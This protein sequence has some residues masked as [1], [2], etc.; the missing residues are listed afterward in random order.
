MKVFFS[1]DAE[2]RVLG[3]G[4]SPSTDNHIEVELD[5]EAD[6]LKSPLSYVIHEGELMHDDEYHALILEEER[7]LA[8]KPSITE[9][10]DALKSVS[11]ALLG[12]EQ[13]E[14]EQ[15]VAMTLNKALQKFASSLPEEEALELAAMYPA[16]EESR[17]YEVGDY[18]RHGLNQDGEPQV[19]VVLQKHDSQSDWSPPATASLFKALGFTEDG[20]PTWVQPLGATD[21]YQKDDVVSFEGVL[22]RS[23][24]DNN[25]WAPNVYGWVLETASA[26]SSA[27]KKK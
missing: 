18:V 21:A 12:G 26:P 1:A 24:M 5:T 15:L 14:N 2:G 9:E 10:V 13:S 7:K 16:W 3:W 27:T 4:T 17:K 11:S 19:Y 25:V 20:T 8:E 22:Y 23:T 6:E